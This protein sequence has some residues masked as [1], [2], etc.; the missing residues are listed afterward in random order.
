MHDRAAQF[1]P[2]A[3]LRGY[4]EVLAEIGR[5]TEPMPDMTPDKRETLDRTL[6]ALLRAGNKP[7]VRIAWFI[8][9]RKKSGGAYRTA[10][11]TIGKV[12]EIARTLIRGDGTIVPI[13]DITT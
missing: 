6:A 5:I 9:D 1:S 3:A 11:G 12:D 2:F 7:I 8:P 10:R 13:N 4:G